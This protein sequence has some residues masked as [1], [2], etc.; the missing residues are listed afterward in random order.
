MLQTAPKS[1]PC[2]SKNKG[3][4]PC[5]VLPGRLCHCQALQPSIGLNMIEWLARLTFTNPGPGNFFL[6][7][8]LFPP[9]YYSYVWTR[10][11][12]LYHPLIVLSLFLSLQG[13]S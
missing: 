11:R 9:L 1:R 2:G 7:L 4:L 6:P 8:I 13:L 5:R 3:E 10:I 12:N